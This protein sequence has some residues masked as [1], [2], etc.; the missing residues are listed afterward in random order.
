MAKLKNRHFSARRQIF[1]TFEGSNESLEPKE[2]VK[3]IFVQIF[4]LV[5]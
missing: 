5:S 2:I 4:F 1:L 3:I